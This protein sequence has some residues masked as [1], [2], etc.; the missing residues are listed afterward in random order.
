ME[1]QLQ[2]I[3]ELYSDI[4]DEENKAIV[5]TKIK[6]CIGLIKKTVDSLDI[7][8]YLLID[9][10]PEISKEKYTDLYFRLGTLYK[11]YADYGVS[12]KMGRSSSLEDFK[13]EILF[14]EKGI[15]SFGRILKVNFEDEKCCTQLVSIFTYL[16]LIYQGTDLDKC[17]RYLNEALFYAPDNET[18]H[19]NLGFLYQKLNK[20]ELSIIHYKT[21][22][23]FIENKIGKCSDERKIELDKLAISNYNGISHIYRS[24]KNW[25]SALFYLRKSENIESEDPEILNQLGVIYTEMRRTDLAQASYDKAISLKNPNNS[26]TKQLLADIYLNYGHMY[27]YNGD[28]VSAVECYNQSLKQNPSFNLPFQNKLMNLSY[29][30]DQFDD[31]MYILN[32]HKLVNKIYQKGNGMYKFDKSFFTHTGKINIGIVSGDFVEHPVSYFIS[33]FLKKYDTSRFNV[34]CYSEC[35]I[36]TRIYNDAIKFKCIRNVSSKQAADII[37]SDNIHVLIDLSGH[38]ALN[39]LDIFALKP[40]PIQISYIGYPYTTGLQEMDYRITDLVCDNQKISQDFY[41]EKLLYLPDC[42]LCYNPCTEDGKSLPRLT[43]V[44]P[45]VNNDGKFLTIGCFN[46]LNKMTDSVIS[47]FNNLLTKYDNIKFVFKTKALINHKVRKTFLEKFDKSVQEHIEIIDCTISHDEHLNTYNRIDIAIDTFPYSGTTT[48][49]EALLMGVPVYSFY[50][51]TYYFHPQNVTSSILKNSGLEEYIVKDSEEL[52]HKITELMSLK[53]NDN[54][55]KTLKK[56]TR[57]KFLSGK[58]CDQ[59]LYMKN[60]TT[61]ITNLYSERSE[62]IERT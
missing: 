40:S 27:S 61:L 9:N 8:E 41:T 28:N 10:N 60:I 14:Y 13:V 37:Y 5:K 29:L 55:W 18:I 43:S 50:D 49:C 24:V 34:T 17:I 7:T 59:N 20:L 30:F 51:Q 15:E 52:Q 22:L 57:E 2:E 44:Q 31:K 53:A 16:C 1:E 33:T 11:V 46:R 62:R 47:V 39:R 58:V 48:S 26:N 12:E 6:K 23:K 21:S 38:T 32:Q 45:Y 36:D 56:N 25:P 42:F 3:Y 54:F 19:Y 4:E 35:V